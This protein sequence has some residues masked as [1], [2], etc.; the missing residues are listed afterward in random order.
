MLDDARVDVTDIRPRRRISASHALGWT[1]R[2]TAFSFAQPLEDLSFVARAQFPEVQYALD[3]LLPAG[4]VVS[5]DSGAL[6]APRPISRCR[7]RERMVE[8][9][10]SSSA[11]V[12]LSMVRGRTHLAGDAGVRQ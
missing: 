7:R 12:V 9:P 11:D 4:S 10:S 3:A 5:I 1:P 2:G 8:A 6:L